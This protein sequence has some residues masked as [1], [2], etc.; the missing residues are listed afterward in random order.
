MPSILIFFMSLKFLHVTRLTKQ[1]HRW[2]SH[3][4][5]ILRLFSISQAT[6]RKM[7]NHSQFKDVDMWNGF[8]TIY[9]IYREVKLTTMLLQI[10]IEI[11]MAKFSFLSAS[12]R[13]FFP[14]FFDAREIQLGR[15]FVFFW[16]AFLVH[17]PRVVVN[18]EKQFFLANPKR[19]K[20]QI[21]S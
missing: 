14:L 2:P 10:S 12:L 1:N 18:G 16:S 19:E 13:S 4:P 5:T 21:F 17:F 6:A 9:N 11:G 20:F 3:T 15:L 7:P 8:F